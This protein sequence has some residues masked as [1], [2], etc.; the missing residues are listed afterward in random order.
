MKKYSFKL[1]GGNDWPNLLI[2]L[3]QSQLFG[4][5]HPFRLYLRYRHGDY[6]ILLGILGFWVAMGLWREDK[7]RRW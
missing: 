2:D 5:F 7:I 3:E 4:F 1:R 6:Y